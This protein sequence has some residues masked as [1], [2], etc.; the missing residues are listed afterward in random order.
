MSIVIFVLLLLSSC[1]CAACYD[2]NFEDALPNTCMLEILILF[3]LG[4][5]V[6]LQIAFW[7]VIVYSIILFAIFFLNIKRVRF[8]RENI[9]AIS[10][11]IGIIGFFLLC[12]FGMLA[13]RISDDFSHW[14]YIVKEMFRLN[15][16]GTNPASDAYFASYPP[17]MALFQYFIQKIYLI[18]NKFVGGGGYFS[19]WH[20]FFAYHI[21]I[22]SLFF[23]FYSL[24]KR[25]NIF[26][27]ATFFISI[28]FLPIT[29]YIGYVDLAIEPALGIL[30]GTGLARIVLEKKKKYSYD[31]YIFLECAML[32]LMK[33]S[34]MFFAVFLALAY[35]I[36]FYIGLK[37]NC[38]E[39][40][41]KRTI[42]KIGIFLTVIIIPKIM[43]NINLL[44]NNTE[45]RFSSKLDVHTYINIVLGRDLSYR[46]TAFHNFLN[47]LFNR[48]ISIDFFN[49]QPNIPITY[50]QFFVL[51]II[52]MC[53]LFK[54]LDLKETNGSLKRKIGVW[55]IIA[56]QFIIYTIGICV[57]Y[58]SNFTEAE[59]IN[60]ASFSRYINVVNLSGYIVVVLAAFGIVFEMTKSGSL[61]SAVVLL[62]VFLAA[63]R[64]YMLKYVSREYVKESVEKR[65]L[66]QPLSD[67][68]KSNCNEDSSICFISQSPSG[69]YEMLGIIF[70]IRPC[71]MKTISDTYSMYDG[72][73]KQ[74]PGKSNVE[75]FQEVLKEQFDYFVL[76]QTDDYFTNTFASA[77]SG[78][79]TEN[80]LY[81]INK[82]NGVLEKV[83]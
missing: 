6:G 64:T 19:E 71:N 53:V 37:T 10:F 24:V 22:V 73:F 13:G 52:L 58:M 15:D 39:H 12:D 33:D 30:S 14:A 23:P 29:F 46:G 26:V 66:Y 76:S 83:E 80:T 59:A 4:L 45:R 41:Y 72:V 38:I 21:F 42:R 8:L 27:Q 55:I 16:F 44:I 63:P 74:E 18:V 65:R 62:C 31:I 61:I 2:V 7:A 77:F 82:E 36:D 54:I 25:K 75:I 28:I 34:G 81:L 9:I 69:G 17:G 47:A 32:V 50:F 20:C 79:I 40:V 11:F 56:L 78:E 48:N 70:M 35:L 43:W 68:I 60:L 49:L 51:I 57:A 67:V 5:F 1:A 3:V